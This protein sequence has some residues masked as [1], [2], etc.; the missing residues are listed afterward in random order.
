MYS[1]SGDKNV[2]IFGQGVA[3][4][5]VILLIILTFSFLFNVKCLLGN[6]IY[7]L[8]ADASDILDN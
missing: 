5:G 6:L 7:L 1:N 2:D 4:G 3:V 8:Y